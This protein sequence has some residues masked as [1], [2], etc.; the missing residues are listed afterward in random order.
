MISLEQCCGLNRSVHEALNNISNV[1]VHFKTSIGNVNS[2][3]YIRFISSPHDL[4]SYICS[5]VVSASDFGTSGPGLI[6]GWAPN[7]HYFFSSFL[8]L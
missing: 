5:L 8:A 6:P 3:K 2:V 1:K 7:I 4:N